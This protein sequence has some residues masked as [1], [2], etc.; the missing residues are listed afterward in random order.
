MKRK[1]NAFKKKRELMKRYG[2]YAFILFILSGICIGC[3]GVSLGSPEHDDLNFERLSAMIDEHIASGEWQ[4]DVLQDPF[5]PEFC[6]DIYGVSDDLYDEV[7]IR[8]SLSEATCE[9]IVVFHAV[10]DKQSDI[11]KRLRA[12]QERRL[13]EYAYLP[14]QYDLMA[15]SEV[16][17]IHHYVFFVCSQDQ[18]NVIKYIR[19]LT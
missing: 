13:K 17:E 6:D 7:L 5:D 14:Y 12:Y 11:A 10:E 18:A 9:E 15:H 19:S 3:K 1:T 2:K 4:M 8:R 16:L